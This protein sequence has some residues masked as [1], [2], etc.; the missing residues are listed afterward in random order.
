MTFILGLIVGAIVTFIF[1]P[2]LD[3]GLRKLVKRDHSEDDD[4]DMPS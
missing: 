3:S 1:K 2:Q 4:Q